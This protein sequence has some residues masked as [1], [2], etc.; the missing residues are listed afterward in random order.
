MTF[1]FMLKLITIHL[2]LIFVFFKRHT[3]IQK[4]TALFEIVLGKKFD[5]K[6]KK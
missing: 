3:R 1:L 2:L 6:N 4:C 5:K